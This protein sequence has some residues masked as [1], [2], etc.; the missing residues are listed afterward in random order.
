MP[1][2]TENLAHVGTVT[3]AVEIWGGGG[4]RARTQLRKLQSSLDVPST[5]AL[6][7]LFHLFSPVDLTRGRRTG[8]PIL[9][10]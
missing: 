9:H 6:C 3:E 8:H 10:L 1:G 5:I 7:V 4:N 2:L